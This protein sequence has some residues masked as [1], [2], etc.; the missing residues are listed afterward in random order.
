M[1]DKVKLVLENRTVTGK[2]VAQI[3]RDE[4]VPGVI[5]GSELDPKNVQFSQQDAIK[6]VRKAGRHTAIEL[7]LGKE[8]MTALI[9]SVDYAPARSDIIHISFQAV[10]A[11][12]VVNTEV[13]LVFVGEEESPAKKAGLIILPAIDKINIKAKVSALPESIELDASQLS[14]SGDKLTLADAKIPSGV[15]VT[16]FDSE[17]VIATV[18]EPAA[19]EAKNAAADEAADAAREADTEEVATEEDDTPAEQVEEVEEK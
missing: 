8:K 2:Q 7:E 10:S 1:P 12:E 5:Y 3:R 19:L 6:I 9:K 13:P 17:L 18:Y 4:L 15:E 14:E 16:D 11:D